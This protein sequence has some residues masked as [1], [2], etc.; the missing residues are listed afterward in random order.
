MSGI[1]SF[2]IFYCGI[3]HYQINVIRLKYDMG[4]RHMFGAERYLVTQV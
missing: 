3:E 4:R 2:V 1:I